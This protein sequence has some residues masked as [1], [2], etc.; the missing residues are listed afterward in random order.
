[1]KERQE[2]ADSQRSQES[3]AHRRES[4]WE[5]G[6]EGHAVAET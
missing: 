3:L 5:E 4:G 2:E 6:S 1:M